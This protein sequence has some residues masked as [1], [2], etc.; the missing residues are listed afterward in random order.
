MRNLLPIV[1]LLGFS[2]CEQYYAVDEACLDKLSGADGLPATSV[3]A[4]SRVNC[5]RRMTGV[6]RVGGNDTVQTAADGEVGYVLLNPDPNLLQGSAGAIPWLSQSLGK[7]GFTGVEAYERLTGDAGY[8][9]AN[10]ATTSWWEYIRIVSARTPEELP[11]GAAAVD[12][13]MR[14]PVFR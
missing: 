4:L 7:P 3:E 9:F 11:T 5:Y 10:L 8:Q 6:L 12:F 2:G 13:L 1:T 14:D